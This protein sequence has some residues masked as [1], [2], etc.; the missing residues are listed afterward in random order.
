MLA[1]STTAVGQTIIYV[2]SL[3]NHELLR[4]DIETGAYIDTFIPVSS[5]GPLNEPHGS[6]ERRSDVLVSSF[7]SDQVLRFDRQTGDFIDVFVDSG[8]G[9]DAPV[10]LRNGPDGYLYL[11]SQACDEIY[12][13][14]AD[15]QLRDVFV[16]AGAGGLDG[17][18]GYD[19]GPDGRLYVASRYSGEIL[20]YDAATGGFIES[21]AD[22]SDGL[23]AG[24]TFGAAFGD[25]GDLYFVSA[26]QV[27]RYDPI[28]DSIVTSIPFGFPI[29]VEAG[30]P[31]TVL[32]ASSGNLFAIDA[33]DNSATGPLL[34]GPSLGTLNFFHLPGESPLVT[35]DADCD[36]A[37]TLTDFVSL[38]DC[39]NGPDQPPSPAPPVT[40]DLCLLWFDGDND[41]DV[42]LQDAAP[43]S[44]RLTP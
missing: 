32:A 3:T 6:I 11:S 33:T 36:G 34:T 14:C 15:G 35:A 38:L 42:D 44:V 31:G 41:N 24:T 13:F 10:L 19:F 30:L 5:N 39:M 20:E 23:T 2:S 16:T 37:I 29:G 4:Y 28:A 7:A 18:S 12:R 40:S 27:F 25:N 17:P 9:I 22:T 43:I 8:V 21:V 1:V 26:N